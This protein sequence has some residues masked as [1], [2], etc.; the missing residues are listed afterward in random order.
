MFRELFFEEFE[1]VFDIMK[2]SF[3]PDEF[4]SFEEQKALLNKENYNIYVYELDFEISG[5]LT[6]W[7]FDDFVYIEH[8][9]VSEKSRN[10]GLG[11]KIL[12]CFKEL[13]R[14]KT[15]ILEVEPPTDTLTKRR[16]NFYIRNGFYLNGYDYIQPPYSKEKRPLK[17]KLMSTGKEIDKDMFEKFKKEVYLVVYG[18]EFD[19]KMEH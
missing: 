14:E 16:V 1:Q 6:F 5:F 4:R 11:E 8:F 17:L 19:F 9:A 12:N 7:T 2:K 10:K 15:I 18:V 3:P 13:C